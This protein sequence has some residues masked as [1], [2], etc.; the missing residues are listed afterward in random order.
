MSAALLSAS[1]SRRDG[2]RRRGPDLSCC[3][4]APENR[5]ELPPCARLQGL[6]LNAELCLANVRENVQTFGKGR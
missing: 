6:G 4:P 3:Q 5:G 1:P 2:Y